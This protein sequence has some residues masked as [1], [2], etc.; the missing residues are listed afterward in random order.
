MPSGSNIEKLRDVS[1]G[2]K[3]GRVHE[4]KIMKRLAFK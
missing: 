3:G 1:E 2:K 4:N